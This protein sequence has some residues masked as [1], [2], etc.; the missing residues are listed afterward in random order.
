M[1]SDGGDGMLEVV[2]EGDV[3]GKGARGRRV[4]TTLETT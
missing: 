3:G 1:L 4:D 2:A